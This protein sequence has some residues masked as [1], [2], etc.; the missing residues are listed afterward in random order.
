MVQVVRDAKQ[1]SRGSYS[2]LTIP[3]QILLTLE[4]WREYR[5]LF[6]IAKDWGYTHQRLNGQSRELKIC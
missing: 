4:Y 1:G 3:D 5:T 6:H 2:K